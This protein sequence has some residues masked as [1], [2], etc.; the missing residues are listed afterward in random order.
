[1][2]IALLQ[3]DVGFPSCT[4]FSRPLGSGTLAI[5]SHLSTI[6]IDITHHSF[7]FIPWRDFGGIHPAKR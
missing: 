7:S 1:M 6:G 5:C 2:L 4:K 3:A